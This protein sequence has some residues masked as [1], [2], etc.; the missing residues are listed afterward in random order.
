MERFTI[1]RVI[2]AQGPWKSSLYRSNFSICIPIW[3]TLI[4]I[5]PSL[6]YLTLPSSLFLLNI[7]CTTQHTDFYQ[8]LISDNK[9]VALNVIF[10]IHLTLWATTRPQ[11]RWLSTYCAKEADNCW[12]NF[13]IAISSHVWRNAVTFRWTYLYLCLDKF[14]THCG[15]CWLTIYWYW[16]AMLSV[17]IQ[18]GGC[19]N[20]KSS[21]LDL[22]L[23]RQS[24]LVETPKTP[25]F[26]ILV[27]LYTD[28]G[29]ALK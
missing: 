18:S 2:L 24:P 25:T 15:W 1:L 22:G 9:M 5:L 12:L 4:V 28:S 20:I 13:L 3:N 27:Y 7:K 23:G 8:W 10:E 21:W 11:I 19:S 29:D 16:C 6:L 17:D 26:S 14:L